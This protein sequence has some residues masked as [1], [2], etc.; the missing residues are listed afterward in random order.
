M[1]ITIILIG[2]TVAISFYAWSKQELL[3]RW[4]LNPYMVST[5]RQYYR[6]ITSGFIHKDHSHLLWNMFSFYFF[7]PAVE[8]YFEYLFGGA[9]AYY[10]VFLYL[11]AI[12]ISDVP[13]YLKYKNNP[14][15][16]AL[17]ASGGIGAVI[18]VFILL[19]PLQSIC[20]YFALCMPGFLFGAGYMIYTYYQ[21]R[22]SNDNINHDA[23]LY[24]ASYGLLFCI[25][26][27]PASLPAFVEQVSTW[28]IAQF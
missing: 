4:I 22:K 1:S 15:Y 5:Q 21:G 2:I 3:R 10:F 19:Q 18:F 8:S 14:G 20:I 16:N 17:G 13:S 11:T 28:V 24:G 27:H 6:F 26:F 7:G 12:V 25:A 9:G 23:H